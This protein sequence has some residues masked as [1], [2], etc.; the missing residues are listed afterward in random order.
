[1]W[2]DLNHTV[3]SGESL[4]QWNR[5]FQDYESHLRE[6]LPRLGTS[7]QEFFKTRPLHDGALTRVEFG[8]SIDRPNAKMG[9]DDFNGRAA[10]A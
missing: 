10:S 5:A 8:D 7:E 1:M 6:L 2:L 3:G 4:E 9:H